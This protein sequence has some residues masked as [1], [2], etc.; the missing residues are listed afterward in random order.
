[1][2]TCTDCYSG[3][4]GIQCQT[5]DPETIFYNKTCV[6][7]RVICRNFGFEDGNV[8][9]CF[10]TNRLELLQHLYTRI[11]SSEEYFKYAMNHHCMLRII[12]FFFSFDI[13]IT[14]IIRSRIFVHLRK[15]AKE[16]NR[17]HAIRRIIHLNIAVFIV[18]GDYFSAN[19]MSTSEY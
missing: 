6:S 15:I 11:L 9:H 5:N 14:I 12:F 16:T 4:Q 1:M 18:L 10:D 13:S 3:L 8:T 7:A 2:S 17:T 19:E